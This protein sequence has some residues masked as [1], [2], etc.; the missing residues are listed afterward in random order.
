M[1]DKRDIAGQWGKLQVD[2]DP[3][4]MRWRNVCLVRILVLFAYFGLQAAWRWSSRIM[5]CH[6][7]ADPLVSV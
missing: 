3:G 4:V 2:T 6:V 5:L 1:E 7:Y